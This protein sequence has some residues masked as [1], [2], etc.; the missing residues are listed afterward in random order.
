LYGLSRNEH[1]ELPVRLGAACDHAFDPPSS[2]RSETDMSAGETQQSYR[3]LW[4]Q[5][6]LQAKADL[7]NEPIGS[8]LFNQAAAFFVN[9]GEWAES[10]LVVA[11]C[12]NMHPDDLSR[13]GQRWIADRRE[14]E[15]LAPE[16][17]RAPRSTA[18]LVLPHLVALPNPEIHSRK[19]RRTVTRA[20]NPFD[21]FREKVAA[22]AG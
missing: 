20:V 4:A 18:P 12:L 6:V 14:R 10:R 8:I 5:V 9:R 13:V 1:H 19:A 7:E 22:T 17:K 21:P 15:G 11:D 2:N 3:V 16:P